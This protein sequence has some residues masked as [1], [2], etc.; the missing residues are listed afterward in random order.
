MKYYVV[1]CL[2]LFICSCSSS[3]DMNLQK[4]G[5]VEFSKETWAMA[6]QEARGAMVYSLSESYTFN[7][8]SKDQI[9]ALLGESTAYYEYDEFP[10][11]FVGS[12]SIES[13]YG[14]GYLLAFPLDRETGLIREVVIIPSPDGI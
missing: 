2:A 12:K 7:E 3:N 10:A 5:T 14:N 6:S 1:L 13:E 8:M 4:L 11:Y 9:L